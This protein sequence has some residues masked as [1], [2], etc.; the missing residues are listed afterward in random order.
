MSNN[1][2]AMT[3]FLFAILKQK[4]LKDIDWNAVARDPI[5][6]Q[7]IT[8]GHAARMRYSRFRQA[9]LG[10]EPK[11]RN[12]VAAE[13]DKH[14]VTKSKKAPKAKR[15][16]TIKSESAGTPSNAT[17]LSEPPT[18]KIKQE[19]AQSPYDSRLTP[20]PVSAA[21]SPALP[22]V[23]QPRLLTPC[24]DTDGFPTTQG[25]TSSPA[26]EMFSTQPPFD[27]AAPHYGH[28]PT[29]W[30]PGPMFPSFHTTFEFDP[31]N[32]ACGYPHMHPHAEVPHHSHGLAENEEGG[33]GV[34]HETWEDH[35]V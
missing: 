35:C 19:M 24:S 27:F 20:G 22:H 30:P 10:L 12:K 2:T 32:M 14:R 15:E 28:D 21:S 11:P 25:L 31:I 6:S 29:A 9:M 33:V 16:D 17:R 1:D 5:L 13:K 26:N 7:E 23:I 34:K 8:N 18:P 3:R 4:N